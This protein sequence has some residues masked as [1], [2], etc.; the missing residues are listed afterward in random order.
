MS[1][2]QDRRA[3]LG[4]SLLGM[5]AA[6][7]GAA[8]IGS[9]AAFAAASEPAAARDKA[10]V[11]PKTSI[12]PGSL[13]CGKIG[14]VSLSR[15]FLG[16][17][18]IGF[19]AHGRDLLYVHHLF[20]HYNTEAK[21]FETLDLA[22][23][24]GVNTILTDAPA[25]LPVL[26]YNQQRQRKMQMMVALGIEKEKAKM[27]E[28]VR[29]T[30]DAG[31]TLVYCHGCSSDEQ[32]MNNRV[33]LIGQAVELIKAGGVPAGVGS[34]S[35]QTTMAAVKHGIEPDFFV[36]TYH[37]DRYWSATPK[38]NRVDWCWYGDDAYNGDDHDKFNDN[39]WCLDADAVVAFMHTVAK[40]WVA[41]KVLA[42][43][44]IHPNVAFPNAYR[45]GA[46]F[47]VAG[48]FDFQLE[49]NVKIAIDSLHK[50]QSRKRPWHG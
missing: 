44:A 49:Q 45:N 23:D 34:H 41:F 46:D 11:K 20:R 30:V 15:L 31:A 7:L 8:G 43:G 19:C 12:A 32:T 3:F 16:G 37:L 40:P 17:N 24:C 38:Q 5:G 48:M 21:I 6:G 10:P 26:K 9:P 2:K 25:W 47:I 18:L 22:L 4:K 14:N 28:A 33:D 50:T 13:A 1:E 35:L 36:K 29:R 42:A 39:M 27:R